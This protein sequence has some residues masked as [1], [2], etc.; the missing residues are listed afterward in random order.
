[1]HMHIYIYTNIS[2]HKNI[3]MYKYANVNIH[4]QTW[5]Y[6]YIY[7]WICKD[8]DIWIFRYRACCLFGLPHSIIHNHY[9]L[10]LQSSNII[11]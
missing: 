8:L 5:I 2:I 1:M 3:C 10:N 6:I 9:D 7:K 11:Q 4:I